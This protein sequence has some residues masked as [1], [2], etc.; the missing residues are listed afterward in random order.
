MKIL[1]ASQIWIHL[2]ADFLGGAAAAGVFMFANSP[3]TEES[4]P[5]TKLAPRLK[6]VEAQPP[7]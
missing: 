5:E 4:V 3:L 6:E 1:T 7:V 2:V